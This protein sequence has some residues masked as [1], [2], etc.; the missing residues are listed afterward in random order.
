MNIK[1]RRHFHLYNFPL[2]LT[3][4]IV[5]TALFA[6]LTSAQNAS[7]ASIERGSQTAKAGFKNEAEI[8][9][10]FNNWKADEDARQWLVSMGHE[11]E[12]VMSVSASNPRGEKSDILISIKTEAGETKQGISI[13]LVSSERGFNQVD[14]RWLSEYA[15]MWKMPSNIVEALKFYC[16]EQLPYKRSKNERRM[17]IN[18]FDE[19]I[20][21]AI[22]DFFT[23][24]KLLIISDMLKGR[25]RGASD[26]FMVAQKAGKGERWK[27]VKIDNAISYFAE[28][29]VEITRSGNLKI[30]RVS[31]QRKGGD[32]GRPTANQLQFKLN[33]AEIF[34]LN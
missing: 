8:A 20:Q 6:Q 9:D 25:G 34:T 2:K 30:G 27:I 22:L 32:G 31:M 19:D 7:A 16:G 12:K 10:K 14:K 18:E 3:F 13:K 26:F 11:I 24:N 17:F 5:F 23:E 28:G 1:K 33:P 21:N 15:R 4:A 29:K